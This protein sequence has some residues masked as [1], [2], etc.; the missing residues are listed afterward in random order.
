MIHYVFTVTSVIWNVYEINYIYESIKNEIVNMCKL[1]LV[2]V[3]LCVFGV[4]ADWQ[5]V[6]SDEFD[7][8]TVDQN[9]WNVRNEI[10]NCESEC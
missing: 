8:L 10:H 7:G 1:I 2:V 9:K 3:V 6:F 4:E 5:L